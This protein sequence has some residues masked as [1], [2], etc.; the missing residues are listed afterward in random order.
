MPAIILELPEN[1]S[2]DEIRNKFFEFTDAQGLNRS[3]AW[4]MFQSKFAFLKCPKQEGKRIHPNE[5][6]RCECGHKTD[7]H[8]PKSCEEANCQFFIREQMQSMFLDIYNKHKAK[9]EN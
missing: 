9:G 2:V 4:D 7:C 8:Y 5:C 6:D 3:I 1:A